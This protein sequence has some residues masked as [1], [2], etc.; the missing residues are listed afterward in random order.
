[1]DIHID[2][3]A[4]ISMQG[5]SAMDIR[6]KYISMNGYPCF[7]GYQSSIIHAFMDIHLD[8][9]GFQFISILDLLWILD[10]GLYAQCSITG[11]R[12]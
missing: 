12:D 9:L 8:I 5:H 1:M 3:Q 11:F 4:G 6:K 7:Y 10:A 2:I